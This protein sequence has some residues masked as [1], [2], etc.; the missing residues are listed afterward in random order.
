MKLALIPQPHKL[1]LSR[2]F[3]KIP[4]S[5][6]IAIS[7]G[8]LYPVAEQAKAMFAR[9]AVSAGI[10]RIADPVRIS[11]RKGLKPGGYRLTIT[12]VAV[13]LEAAS[14]TAAFHGLQTLLQI[15]SQS[16]A[17]KLPA[18]RIDDW[19]DFQ[20]RGVYYDVC[21]GR[22]PQLPR[23][24]EQ[25]ALL[26]HFKIN[27][28]QLYIEHTFKFRGHPDIGKGAS[29]LTAEDVLV[30]DAWCR[31]FQV[32]FVPSL[33]SFGHLASV[34][35]HP[36]YHH[37]AEDWGVGRY[38]SPE[39]DKL[40]PWMKHKAWSLSPANPKVYPFLDSLYS[41][42]LPLFSSKRFNACCDETFDLGLG[43]THDLCKKKGKG[44]VYLDHIVKLNHLS[45]KY[46]KK[47]M[48]WGDI[49]RHYPKLINGIPKDALVLDWGYA[50]NH[51]FDRIRDFRK[52]GLDFYACPGTSSWVSLFPRLHNAMANI[53]G[54][55]AAAK[56]N[57]GRGLLNTDWGDGGHYN[58]MEYSWH[59]FLFGAEQ[60]WNTD[61][62]RST[63]TA[64]F[65]KLFLGTDDP[66]L[67]RAI[68]TLGEV[69]H[70]SVGGYYQSA[71]QH[72]FF[73]GPGHDVFAPT[74]RDA[75]ICRDGKIRHTKLTLNAEIG[76]YAM[77]RLESVRNALVAAACRPGADPHGVL[78][79]WI[80]AVDTIA[81]AARKLTVLGVGGRNTLPERRALKKE[82]TSL[83]RQF[84]R[85]WMARNR[86]SEIRVTL[87][88]YRN[89]IKMLG[90]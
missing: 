23:L 1:T 45:R 82:M 65:A 90:K 6:T 43:Q 50:F 27:Q 86:P 41:E 20:D 66:A 52:A 32:D 19:P 85:L 17:G 68:D 72:I 36:Q 16:P 64:R 4:S 59:G 57:K 84:E 80:F 58:F 39:A 33:A 62:D 56:K 78:P 54:F 18:L 34:L 49:I 42:F 76:R 12:S 24:M 60:A 15:A 25:V 79:Y 3:F 46:G 70:I 48:F 7:D 13:A 63:F 26:S 30:L 22:V 11:L 35:K 9:Y 21:R 47:I 31:E 40:L 10:R 61:A 87:K 37:L 69:T 67:V 77:K 73:A 2:G 71:W 29:P 44:Q 14:P 5:G 89:A 28:Y 8:S 75:W 81:H 38:V 83:M 51:P 74:R 53:H 55:A 88:R